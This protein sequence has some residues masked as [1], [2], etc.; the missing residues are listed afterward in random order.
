MIP[1]IQDFDK[2]DKGVLQFLQHALVGY[3]LAL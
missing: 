1:R 3:T 2:Q